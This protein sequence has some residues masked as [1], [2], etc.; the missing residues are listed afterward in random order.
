MTYSI[1]AADP[2]RDQVGVA[3]QSK[4]LAVG[5]LVPWARGG[6]GACAVQAFPD[7][8]VGPRALDR[9]EAGEDPQAILDDLVVDDP[10]AA[11][12]QTGLVAADGRA[13]SHTGEACF[14]WRGHRVG[15]GFAIQGNVLVGPEVVDAM[16]EAFL[17]A[18][19]RPL[20][21][22]LLAALEAGQAAGGEKR[23]MESAAV[24]V[25][26]P[27]GGY[28]GN[29]DRLVDLRV[30][31]DDDPIT[32][33]GEL[34]E[35]RDHHFDRAP[36]EEWVPLDDDLTVE[37]AARLR[38]GGWLAEGQPLAHALMGYL[39]WENLEERWTDAVSIDPVALAHLR[40]HLPRSG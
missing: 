2:D 29:H 9:L 27:G 24:V 37:V 22:R 3:V 6:V 31:H 7:V 28:G 1:A 36:A 18:T 38:G 13:A 14:A 33:L 11:Q 17:A 20:A 39:G 40:R 30:D 21:H 12:R 25:R 19:A 5:N 23:G 34:L 16:A 35:I 10:M 15:P 4:F 32:R 26:Q 8:T